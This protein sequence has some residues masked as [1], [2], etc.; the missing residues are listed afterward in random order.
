MFSLIQI[1]LILAFIKKVIFNKSH[2]MFFF[3]NKAVPVKIDLAVFKISGY[4][5]DSGGG[6]FPTL[7]KVHAS[8]IDDSTIIDFY[9][10]LYKK[11]L[12]IQ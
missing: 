5:L 8:V 2:Y 12:L 4:Y 10:N 11:Y 7:T 6:S 3:N 9:N 1:T